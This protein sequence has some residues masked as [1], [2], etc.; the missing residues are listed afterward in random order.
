MPH[1]PPPLE[2]PVQALH[3]TLDTLEK[4][5]RMAEARLHPELLGFIRAQAASMQGRYDFWD[6]VQV[7]I[8]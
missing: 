6:S 4:I 3:G 7:R 5:L 8:D 1:C 2:P